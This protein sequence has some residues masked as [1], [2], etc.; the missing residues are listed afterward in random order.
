MQTGI[1][2]H[3]AIKGTIE[4]RVASVS[5][6]GFQCA[7]IALS[8]LYDDKKFSANSALTPG[9]AMYLKHLFEKYNLDI[10][11]LGNY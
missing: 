2:L 7:H 5:A 3:D 1:R 9:Y 8:K 10:A 4:E 6:Q 11:V